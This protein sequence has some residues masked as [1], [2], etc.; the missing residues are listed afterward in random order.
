MGWERERYTWDAGAGTVTID[1]LD[2]NLWGTGSGWQYRLTAADGGTD[3]H[4]TLKRA[5]KGLRGK[6]IGA[7][8][9]VAGARVL[10]KQFRSV[11]KKAEAG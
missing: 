8:I 1:T 3:V 7:L 6:L 2:S 4:V 5:G 9:P 10:G 11:L